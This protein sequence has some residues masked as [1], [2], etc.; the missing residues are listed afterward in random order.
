VSARASWSTS[1]DRAWLIAAGAAACIAALVRIHNGLALPPLHD[2][3]GAGHVLNVF[4]FREG[5][6]PS[7]T[8]WS[9]FHPPL[10]HATCA[11]LWG[12][13]PET[14]PVHVWMRWLSAAAGFGAVAVIWG[15]LERRA[16]RSDAASVAAFVLGVP[17]FAIATST[18]GNETTGVFFVTLAL[19]RLLQTSQM[20][21]AG[22]R[23]ALGTAVLLLLALLG[24]ATGLLAVAAAF[25][26][27]LLHVRPWRRGLVS[28]GLVAGIPLALAAPHYLRIVRASS[29]PTLAAVSGVGLSPD[30]AMMDAQQPP[31]E[32]RLVDYF[33]VPVATFLAPS[34][35]EPGMSRSVPGLLYASLW[36]DTHDVFVRSASPGPRAAG[37]PVSMRLRNAQAAMVVAGLLPTALALL[38]T[39]CLLRRR[40]PSLFGPLLFGALLVASLL[41]HAWILPYYSAVKASY[42]LSAAL[43]ACLA[44]AAGLEAFSDRS[45]AAPR[46][47]LLVLS[48]FGTA[49]TGYAC[50]H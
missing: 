45:R 17:A 3:D 27:Y 22:A 33:Y 23:H 1:R 5:A 7:P 39:V 26:T 44:L 36:A 43:P 35:R 31:G 30:L 29:A 46:A 16:S 18:L 49:L 15:V 41:R 24:K 19:A 12:L 14:V 25:L 28:A 48:V 10:Y 40:D 11:L 4:A 32:R 37:G 6:L 34:Y 20:A 8:S 50:W 21:R 2:P 9:G 47:I 38:G 42:L 13:A